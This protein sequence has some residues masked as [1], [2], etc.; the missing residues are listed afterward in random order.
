MFIG[1]P[2]EAWLVIKSG[3]QKSTGFDVEMAAIEF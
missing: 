3:R 1:V 2:I